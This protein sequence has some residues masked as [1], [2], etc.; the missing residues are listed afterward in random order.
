MSQ[1]LDSAAE[2]LPDARRTLASLRRGLAA[3]VNCARERTDVVLGWQVALAAPIRAEVAPARGA[4]H[5][6]SDWVEPTRLSRGLTT[7]L[8]S[9]ISSA[10][11][12]S[13]QLSAALRRAAR[14][15]P[16]WTDVCPPPMHDLFMFHSLWQPGGDE[17]GHESAEPR[18]VFA[19]VP[20]K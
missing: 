14:E 5:H 1:V 20:V 6:W 18:T 13:P 19:D 15:C 16:V 10:F 4:R 9:M 7:K 2:R 3:E 17:D 11:D 8:V 12:S